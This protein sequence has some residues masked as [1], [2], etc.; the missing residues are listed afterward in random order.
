MGATTA[1]KLPASS[2]KIEGDGRL[3]LGAKLKTNLAFDHPLPPSSLRKGLRG[4]ALEQA[5]VLLFLAL[6]AMTRPR[7]RLQAFS[8]DFPLAGHT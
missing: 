1:S 2:L 7:H 4:S 8:L 6:D 3:E 5:L